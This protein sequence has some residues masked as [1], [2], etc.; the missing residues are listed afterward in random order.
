MNLY[1]SVILVHLPVTP[2]TFIAKEV[3]KV[4]L[5][6]SVSPSK[7]KVSSFT[8]SKVMN[9]SETLDSL[10]ADVLTK[11]VGDVPARSQNSQAGLSGINRLL[12]LYEGPNMGAS[13]LV[14]VSHAG[15]QCLYISLT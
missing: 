6:P 9:R 10:L 14:K 2:R 12:K 13:F 5:L 11:G 7:H 4:S 3:C 1:C 15:E 8:S